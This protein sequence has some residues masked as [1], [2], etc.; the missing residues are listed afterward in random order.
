MFL[1]LLYS[2]NFRYI[3]F[4]FI[5]LM[6]SS[7]SIQKRLYQKGYYIE[8]LY[9]RKI[10]LNQHQQ[11]RNTIKDSLLLVSNS[12]DNSLISNITYDTHT[13]LNDT[14]YFFANYYLHLDN[15]KC[16]TKQ[17]IKFN[18]LYFFSNVFNNLDTLNHSSD[19]SFRKLLFKT[20]RK[21]ATNF[22]FF[23]FTYWFLYSGILGIF[24][25]MSGILFYPLLLI[26]L[27]IWLINFIIMSIIFFN[28]FGGTG[29]SSKQKWILFSL[30]FF[31]FFICPILV[32]VYVFSP[33]IILI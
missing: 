32:F 10:V 8:W 26:S 15:S 20:I 12:L 21:T 11:N 31:N 3:L 14:N 17:K 22:I 30:W 16:G 13:S 29:Y 23:S 33:I 25:A 9:K 24:S 18:N 28:V 6:C 27:I 4:L 19:S 5:F 7:C 2:N 1:N